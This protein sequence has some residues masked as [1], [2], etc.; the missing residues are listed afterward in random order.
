MSGQ[1]SLRKRTILTLA[2][3]FFIKQDISPLTQAIVTN[4]LNQSLQKD[5]SPNIFASPIET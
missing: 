2:L 5:F 1:N 3:N 4:P